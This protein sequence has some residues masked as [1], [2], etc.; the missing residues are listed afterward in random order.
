M[1]Q[2]I[3]FNN[4]EID[5]DIYGKPILKCLKKAKILFKKM[6]I[7]NVYIS[8]TDEDKYVFALVILEC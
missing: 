6:H 8:L 4:F 5:H 3:R 1:R 7:K 2:G